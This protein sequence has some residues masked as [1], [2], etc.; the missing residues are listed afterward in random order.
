M[1]SLFFVT[2]IFISLCA[3]TTAI[4]TPVPAYRIPVYSMTSKKATRGNMFADGVIVE[5]TSSAI[6]S[7]PVQAPTQPNVAPDCTTWKEIRTSDFDRQVS[8]YMS[9][10]RLGYED[11]LKLNP[12]VPREQLIS[13]KGEQGMG[14]GLAP[15]FTYCW[16]AI[17]WPEEGAFVSYR[18][19]LAEFS[20]AGSEIA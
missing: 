17:K 5:F 14:T 8:I 20:G 15:G 10:N 7:S 12:D 13:P 9:L 1:R 4:P 6:A 18:V 19:S 11:F 3:I 16:S 2:P